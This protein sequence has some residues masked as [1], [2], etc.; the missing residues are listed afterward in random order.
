MSFWHKWQNMFL[1]ICYCM[2]TRFY[3]FGKCLLGWCSFQYYCCFTMS[4]CHVPTTNNMPYYT[5]SVWHVEGC[6]CTQVRCTPPAHWTQ[7]YRVVLHHV[8]SHVEECRCTQVKCTLPLPQLNLVVKSPTTPC[9]FDMWK[10]AGIPRS[11]VHPQL[12]EPSATELYYTMSVWYVEEYRCTQVR[13]SPQSNLVVQSPTTPCQFDML[14]N[15]G[16]PRSDVP[17]NQT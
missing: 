4:E 7:Y 10:N 17:P 1:Q 16:V 13:S 5:M 3:I 9:Q 12:I 14:K 6:R 15:A 2:M 11:D 8:S